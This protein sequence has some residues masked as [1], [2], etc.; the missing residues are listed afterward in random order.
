MR[1]EWWLFYI[2]TT[3]YARIKGTK[4]FMKHLMCIFGSVNWRIEYN[5]LFI[6]SLTRKQ[7]DDLNIWFQHHYFADMKVR[8]N[9]FIRK[10]VYRFLLIIRFN[11]IITL[12]DIFWTIQLSEVLSLLLLIRTKIK[13]KKVLNS[14]IM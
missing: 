3:V 8:M 4:G 14:S 12:Y 2:H 11:Q 6:W 13:T 10:L 7:K 9:K 5:V 1:G